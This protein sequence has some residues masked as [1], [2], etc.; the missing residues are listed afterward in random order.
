MSTGQNARRE[1]ANKESSMKTVGGIGG[2]GPESA[3]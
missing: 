2:V 1:Y 3:I